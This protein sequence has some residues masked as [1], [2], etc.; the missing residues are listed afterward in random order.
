LD[1]LLS[2]L[3]YAVVIAWVF[4]MARTTGMFRYW[5]TFTVFALVLLLDHAVA[6]PFA[7]NV[8]DQAMGQ[9]VTSDVRWLWVGNLLLMYL[10]LLVGIAL[11]NEVT[12]Y[13]PN[14]LMRHPGVRSPGGANKAF[15]PAAIVCLVLVILVVRRTTG[16][17]SLTT[18]LFRNLTTSEY[19]AG[20]LA[21]GES[22]GSLGGLWPYI[23]SLA[24]YSILPLAS[25]YCLF[26]FR[27]RW[28]HRLLLLISLGMFLYVGLISG[29]KYV[30]VGILLT[31]FL[32]YSMWRS[33]MQVR[34]NRK[35]LLIGFGAVMVV[36]PYLYMV[37]YPSFSYWDGLSAVGFRL[38]METNR[39]L[40][41]FYVAYPRAHPYLHGGSSHFAAALLGNS[42]VPPHTFVPD[43]LFGVTGTTW[44]AVYIG[45][46]WADFGVFGTIGASVVVGALL[47]GYNVWFARS[48]RTAFHTATFAVLCASAVKL[49][50]VGLPTA[51][52]TFGLGTTFLAFLAGLRAAPPLLDGRGGGETPAPVSPGELG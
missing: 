17:V 23:A 6:V 25:V 42:Q 46:A 26:S 41:L 27:E 5:N 9:R 39:A 48:R 16:A 31:L 2:L 18:F 24:L 3:W 44:N 7:W 20:R 33:G 36:F 14:E 47:Q 32:G 19:A 43:A 49:A 30:A 10:F 37:Q 15:M 45:D 29:Q 8:V 28:T 38:T 34:L 40:Q 13:R 21:F 35:L 1:P 52:V 22:F 4:A 11:V 51:L 50:A 12:G